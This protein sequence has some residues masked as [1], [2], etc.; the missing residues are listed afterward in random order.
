MFSPKFFEI[1]KNN[2][3]IKYSKKIF[4]GAKLQKSNSNTMD[5]SLIV[6]KGAFTRTKKN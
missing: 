3:G 6:G 2:I 1:K 5:F 4:Q